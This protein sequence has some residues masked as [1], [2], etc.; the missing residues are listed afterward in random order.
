MGLAKNNKI[1]PKRHRGFIKPGK[2]ASNIRT[3]VIAKLAMR[4][5]GIASFHKKQLISQWVREYM[6]SQMT[7]LLFGAALNAE[8]FKRQTIRRVDIEQSARGLPGYPGIYSGAIA[9]HAQREQNKKKRDRTR[10]GDDK[11]D[12]DEDAKRVES[13][14]KAKPA[15]SAAAATSIVPAIKRQRGRP[16]KQPVPEST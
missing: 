6:K 14:E 1:Q 9:I 12:D 16:K 15:T 7:K 11:A 5:G 8:A 2:D 4:G 13:K 3:G 10:S